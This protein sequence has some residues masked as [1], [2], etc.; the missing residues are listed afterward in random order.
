MAKGPPVWERKP[1]HSE[2]H[3]TVCADHA[4]DQATDQ[5]EATRLEPTT[6]GILAAG[7]L[8]ALPVSLMLGGQ[9][10]AS[11]TGRI[12]MPAPMGQWRAIFSASSRSAHSMT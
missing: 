2:A 12:S 10:G 7:R 11:H 6:L 8:T 3:L 4:H 1:S 9:D 5:E